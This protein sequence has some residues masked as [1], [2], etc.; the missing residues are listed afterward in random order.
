MNKDQAGPSKSAIT[1]ENIILDKSPRHCRVEE[2]RTQLDSQSS[3]EELSSDSTEED[4]NPPLR[5]KWKLEKKP[6]NITLILPSKKL[7]TPCRNM[8]NN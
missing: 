5:L 1:E 2:I 3:Q 4:W 6:E 7:P 8:H